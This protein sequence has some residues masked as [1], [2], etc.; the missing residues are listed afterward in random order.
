MKR[1]LSIAAAVVMILCAFSGCGEK[2]AKTVETTAP[3]TK[4]TVSAK[5]EKGSK[6]LLD[7]YLHSFVEGDSPIYGTWQ[8]EGVDYLSFIFRNDGL[9]EMVMDSEGDFTALKLNEKKKTIELYFALGLNGSYSYNVSED[10]K[11]LTLSQSKKEITLKKQKDYSIVPKAPKKAKVDSDLIG[12]WK[13]EEK[14]FYYF[15]SDGIMYSNNISMETA[16]TYSAESGVIN[17]VYN[18]GGEVKK[19]FDY[20]IKAGKLIMDDQSFRKFENKW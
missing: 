6:A 13:S 17:A 1:F 9:A 12:W 15:G 5:A 4:K 3:T 10:G 2:P 8:I 11:T 7:S 18:Y 14:Q 20:N 16:Y 19:D